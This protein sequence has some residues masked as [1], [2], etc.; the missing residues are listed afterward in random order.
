MI[1]LKSKF[2]YI[3][4]RW[5]ILIAFLIFVLGIAF[6]SSRNLILVSARS[7]AE[8]I[9]LN[10]ADK[11][12]IEVLKEENIK[13]EEL[14]I[15]SRNSEGRIIGIE[16]DSVKADIIKSKLSLK[17]TEILKKNSNFK[18]SIPLGNFL[19]N[20]YTSG[21]GPDLKFDIQM[22]N[23]A[24]LDF[25]SNFKNSGIN[26]TLHQILINFDMTANIVIKGGSDAF[27]VNTSIIVAQTVIS[28]EIP[29]SFTNV[30]ENPGD[31]IADDIF[32][33]AQ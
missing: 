7:D 17:T 1:E 5:L 12:V 26:N 29:D 27:K 32:N 3:A 24:S 14:A 23:T 2:A 4:V 33:F 25:K 28:G 30:T 18:I 31:D 19:S 16:I 20:D 21:L 9:M 6:F 11:A 15:I 22:T 13:Y 10:A 8:A